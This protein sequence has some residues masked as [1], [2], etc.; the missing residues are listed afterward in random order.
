[1]LGGL[2]PSY[3]A[4]TAGGDEFVNSGR[5]F[6][7]VKNGHTSPQTVTVNSQTVCNQ[8]YDHD[9]PVVIP[10]SEERMIG[11][12]PKGRFDDANGKV[13]ITYSGVTA[14][15]IAAVRVP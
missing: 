8:G 3:A 14:L 13:Q 10:A 1:M 5:E 11:P 2:T 7:H 6:I 9:A 12:F 4:A 15:T